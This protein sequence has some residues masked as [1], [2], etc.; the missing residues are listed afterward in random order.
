MGSVGRTSSLMSLTPTEVRVAVNAFEAALAQV[1]ESAS[2]I[3]AY[4]ARQNLAFVIIESAL[5][6]ERDVIR[7]RDKGLRVLGISPEQHGS[8]T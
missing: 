1:D 4:S 8:P 2:H 3:T 5:A 7:L 6:G